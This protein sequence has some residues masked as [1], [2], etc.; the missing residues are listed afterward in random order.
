MNLNLLNDRLWQE[1]VI[2]GGL[3][4]ERETFRKYYGL[5]TSDWQA[6]TCN[7]RTASDPKHALKHVLKQGVPMW[8]IK[9]HMD[10]IIDT[11]VWTRSHQQSY[12]GDYVVVEDKDK[13]KFMA[14]DGFVLKYTDINTHTRHKRVTLGSKTTIENGVTYKDEVTGLRPYEAITVVASREMGIWSEPILRLWQKVSRRYYKIYGHLC[15]GCGSQYKPVWGYEHNTSK[16]V[17]QNICP[18]CSSKYVRARTDKS[19][20]RELLKLIKLI[21]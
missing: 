5:Y 1:L 20:Q 18:E 8:F 9:R 11:S 15:K 16:I 6:H 2:R 7:W 3:F 19:K 13:L 10:F 17:S 12:G 14:N 21:A 4:D